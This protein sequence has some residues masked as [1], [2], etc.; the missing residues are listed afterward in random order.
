MLNDD[1]N[2]DKNLTKIMVGGVLIGGALVFAVGYDTGYQSGAKRVPEP[3]IIH[4]NVTINNSINL[5][6]D[7]AGSVSK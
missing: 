4:G 3:T 5:N 2:F 1:D 6:S 7:D